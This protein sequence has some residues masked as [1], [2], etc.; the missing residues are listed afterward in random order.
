MGL[1]R[2]G[3]VLGTKKSPTEDE[4]SYNEMLAIIYSE[5]E[6]VEKIKLIEEEK[7][8]RYEYIKSEIV[9]YFKNT[10]SIESLI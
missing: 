9:K 5:D 1:K 4:D 6:L 3:S 2:L 10:H 7:A 8:W